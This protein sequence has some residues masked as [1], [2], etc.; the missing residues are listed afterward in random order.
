MGT[1]SKTQLI[2]FLNPFPKKGTYTPVAQSVEQL[3]LKQ[4][5]AGSSPVWST[6]KR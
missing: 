4:W 6:T 2:G 1:N 5:V 3:T